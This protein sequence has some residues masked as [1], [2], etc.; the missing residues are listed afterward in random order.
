VAGGRRGRK[1]SLAGK[2]PGVVT[3]DNPGDTLTIN[4]SNCELSVCK[5]WIASHFILGAAEMLSH[6]HAVFF[7]ELSQGRVVDRR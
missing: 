3:F 2:S 5:R 4:A 6:Q 1:R 7:L